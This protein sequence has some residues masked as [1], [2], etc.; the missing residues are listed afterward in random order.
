MA[1]RYCLRTL[2][3]VL[4]FTAIAVAFLGGFVSVLSEAQRDIRA[5]FPSARDEQLD[6][7]SISFNWQSILLVSFRWTNEGGRFTGYWGLRER[8]VVN[9]PKRAT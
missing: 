9:V 1:M 2:L 7:H 8:Q 6:F 4:A 5:S 3:I